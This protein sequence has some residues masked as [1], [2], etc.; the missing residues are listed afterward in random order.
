MMNKDTFAEWLKTYANI[1]PY[2]IGRYSK[3]IVTISSGLGDYGLQRINLFHLTETTFIDEIMNNPEFKK[4]N[5][6]GHRMYS[7]ALNHFKKYIEYYYE[8]EFQAELFKEEHEF[9]KYLTVIPVVD[10]RVKVEDKPKDKPN[11]R[12]VNNKKVWSRNSKYAI[13]A[14]I[15]A[16]YQCEFDNQHRYFLSK[17]NGKNYVEAHH[18]IPMQY[19]ER[20]NCSLDIHA[21]IVSLCLICHK[22]IHFG[23]FEDKK[24]ILDK[25]FNIRKERLINSGINIGLDKLYSYYKD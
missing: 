15:D 19:Q 6:K 20:Y 11:Y 2:S 7:V 21:N 18:L 24:E 3:A 13:E 5:E 9:D 23:L 8:F 1:K 17:F 10:S 14:V 12:S 4:K 16:D 22:K 25:L